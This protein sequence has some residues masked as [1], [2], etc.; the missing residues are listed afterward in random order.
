MTLNG[1][2]A[3]ISC[4]LIEFGGFRHQLVIADEDR[5]TVC[6]ISVAQESNFSQYMIVV[7]F[8]KITERKL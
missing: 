6:N 4:H 1:I 3:V 7:I 2:V 8:S 5:H